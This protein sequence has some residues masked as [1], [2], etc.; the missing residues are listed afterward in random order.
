MPKRTEDLGHKLSKRKAAK[1]MK[2]KGGFGTRAKNVPPPFM[3]KPDPGEG[4]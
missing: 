2:K 1:G 3:K 4:Y